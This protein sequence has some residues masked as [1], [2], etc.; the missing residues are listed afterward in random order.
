MIARFMWTNHPYISWG[1]VIGTRDP[2][3]CIVRGL[4]LAMSQFVGY[5][6]YV[7]VM[8]EIEFENARA[9]RD[10]MNPATQAVIV[11]LF[12]SIGPPSVVMYA[13]TVYYKKLSRAKVHALTALLYGA[14]FAG[15]FFYC[16]STVIMYMGQS[17]VCI[18]L[19]R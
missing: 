15:I 7:Y 12:N 6:F 9:N 8:G 3:N 16:F 4:V 11:G 2:Y 10:E 13:F 5:T 1:S 14:G 17:Q 19:M 18:S